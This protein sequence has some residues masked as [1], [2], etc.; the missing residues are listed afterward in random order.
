MTFNSQTCLWSLITKICSSVLYK[1]AHYNQHFGK[2]QNLV[3]ICN[4]TQHCIKNGAAAAQVL[5]CSKSWWVQ[6]CVLETGKIIAQISV[7]LFK[8]FIEPSKLETRE[9]CSVSTHLVVLNNRLSSTLRTFGVC[10]KLSL[11][12]LGRESHT[13]APGSQEFSLWQNWNSDRKA[14]VSFASFEWALEFSCELFCLFLTHYL[15]FCVSMG[16]SHR[17]Y[18]KIPSPPIHL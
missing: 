8:S 18:R 7:G 12:L 10:L 4:T 14:D 11:V 6:L 13:F 9:S 3:H 15:L 2:K 1:A 17:C 5:I 16:F